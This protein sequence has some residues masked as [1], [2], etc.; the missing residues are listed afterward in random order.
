MVGFFGMAMILGA[1]FS[2]SFGYVLS[3]N[4]W[5]QLANLFGG[6]AFIYYTTKKHAWAS[7]WV[8]VVWVI[9]AVV[10]LGKMFL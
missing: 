2:T 1:Y 4:I 3:D 10:S 6:A 8:N 5:Y 7:L 9:I